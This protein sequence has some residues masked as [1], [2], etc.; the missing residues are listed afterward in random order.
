[1]KEIKVIQESYIRAICE[2]TNLNERKLRSLLK[3]KINVYLTAEEA[4]QHGFA[5]IVV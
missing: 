2:E 3:K 4:V 1:M 5:D